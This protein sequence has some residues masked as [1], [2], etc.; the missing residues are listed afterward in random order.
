MPI[1]GTKMVLIGRE[2][3]E[4]CA[5]ENEGLVLLQHKVCTLPVT[6]TGSGYVPSKHR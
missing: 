5:P 6:I 2:M 3:H 4:L 1:F